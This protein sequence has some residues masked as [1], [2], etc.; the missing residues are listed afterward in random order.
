[1]LLLG[2]GAM[3]SLLLQV[4]EAILLLRMV[5]VSLLTV[6]YKLKTDNRVYLS[7]FSLN[8]FQPYF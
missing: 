6:V 3:S 1:M 5:G 4:D 7:Y 8:L 2:T